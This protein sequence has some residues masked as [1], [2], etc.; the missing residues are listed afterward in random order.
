[1]DLA[2]PALVSPQCD[3]TPRYALLSL[4]PA[5]CGPEVEH[6]DEGERGRDGEALEIRCFSLRVLGY[7]RDSC[8]E[9]L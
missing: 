4:D 3:R 6:G 9:A 7:E 5:L 2:A 1:M 8:I